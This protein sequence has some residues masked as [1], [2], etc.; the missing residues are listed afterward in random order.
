V[1]FELSGSFPVGTDVGA[2]PADRWSEPPKGAPRGA[3]VSEATIAADGTATLTLEENVRYYVAGEID[4]RWVYVSV[5]AAKSGS[6]GGVTKEEV[7]EIVAEKA[8]LEEGKLVESQ[9]PDSVASVGADESISGKW[10]F[11]EADPTTDGARLWVGNGG[12]PNGESKSVSF[13]ATQE[14]NNPSKVIN[15]HRVGYSFYTGT[16]TEKCGSLQGGSDES[17]V[18]ADGTVVSPTVL[19]FEGIGV[20]TGE[21]GG[22][23][24]AVVGSQGTAKAAGSGFTI[25][26]LISLRAS[27]ARATSG[28]PTVTKGISFQAL[29][30]T[31]GTTRRTIEA[32]GN[33]WLKKGTASEQLTIV[34][35]AE[36]K[37][38]GVADGVIT[39][40]ASDGTSARLTLDSTDAATYRL[41]LTNSA[42]A[43]VG[44]RLEYGL[45]TQTGNWMEALDGVGATTLRFAVTGE[46]DVQFRGVPKWLNSANEQTTVGAEGAAS[47]LPALPTKYLKVKDHSG[48]T[49]VVPAYAAA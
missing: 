27:A 17:R 2:Y 11:E 6:K 39:G 42:A 12:D 49:L 19:G 7:E 10:R 1:E 30:P 23:I 9:L 22:G 44:A 35:S 29:E 40:Y 5:L 36:V 20:G 16:P 32:I 37:K 48:T 8:D 43:T 13:L 18:W 4:G 26:S 21:N 15:Q 31:V 41:R 47:A 33:T 46:G 45:G 14:I 34:N 3:A 28:A 24:N 38:W 25:T